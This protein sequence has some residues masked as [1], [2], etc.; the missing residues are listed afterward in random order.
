[1]LGLFL[2]EKRMERR[3]SLR[4]V[5]EKVGVSANFLSLVE[6][7]ECF[8]SDDVLME[9]SSFY[10]VDFDRLKIMMGK[11]SEEMS[12]LLSRDVV[13]ELLKSLKNKTDDEVIKYIKEVRDGN[14]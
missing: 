2:K 9:L 12:I 8:P 7:G 3:F 4:F 10:S 6:R 11:I 14:W 5:A 13:F 1:M